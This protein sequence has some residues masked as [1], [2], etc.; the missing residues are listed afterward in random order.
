MATMQFT[1]INEVSRL[2]QWNMD[3]IQWQ[4]IKS[5]EVVYIEELFYLLT[6]ASFMK[7]A[8][9]RCASNFIGYFSDDSAVTLWLANHWQHEEIQ[10]GE[11]LKKYV[12]TVW[13]G[14]DWDRA[15]AGFLKEYTSRCDGWAME[16][17]RS[18]ELAARCVVEISTAGFY[19]ALSRIS[20][21][22]V[23]GLLAQHIYED[24]MRHYKYFHNIFRKYQTIE[25]TSR[26]L[27]LQT[28]WRRL[29]MISIHDSFVALKHADIAYHPNGNYCVRR[30]RFIHNRCRQLLMPHFPYRMSVRM[31]LRTLCLGQRTK[32]MMAPVAGALARYFVN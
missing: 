14:L 9:Q 17:S 19:T 12:Q 8:T 32:Y 15:Y 2:K 18:Q 7:M 11:V 3:D 29:K 13:P 1:S 30:H 28:L 26:I 24:E 10:H 25:H 21:D 20:R 31:L 22:P 23:L 5:D 6:T 4:A 16:P 27:L